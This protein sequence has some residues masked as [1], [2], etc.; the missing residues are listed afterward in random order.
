M[1]YAC[2]QG[3]FVDNLQGDSMNPFL[4]AAACLTVILGLIHSI[5]GERLFTRWRQG[6]VVAS[7]SSSLLLE[8]HSHILRATWHASSVLGWCVAAI[9]LQLAFHPSLGIYGGVIA[10]TVAIFMLLG[11]VLVF[12]CTKGRHLGWLGLSGI[13]ALAWASDLG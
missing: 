4:I 3:P 5:L 13:A 11:A 1:A 9:L 12:L 2:V 8:E 6:G 7:D 10:R